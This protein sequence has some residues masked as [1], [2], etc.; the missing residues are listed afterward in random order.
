MESVSNWDHFVR[1]ME[2]INVQIKVVILCKDPIYHFKIVKIMI[3][4]VVQ[5]EIRVSVMIF[6]YIV[7]G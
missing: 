7:I 4:L 6:N 2:V 1:I 5:Q 3:N